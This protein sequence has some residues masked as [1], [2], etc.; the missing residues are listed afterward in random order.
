MY[1][2]P[3]ADSPETVQDL[4]K[5]LQQAIAVELTV[6]PPLFTAL[7]S[8]KDQNSESAK[9][10]HT[11]V[12]E[13]MLHMAVAGNL[14]NAIGGTVDLVSVAKHFE[15]L[16]EPLPY[17]PF[18]EEIDLPMV[19]LQRCSVELVQGLFSRVER[20]PSAWGNQRAYPAQ[21]AKFQ[22]LGG[23]YEA[24]WQTF[25]RLGESVVVPDSIQYELPRHQTGGGRLWQVRSLQ[26]ALDLITENHLKG[27]T[28]ELGSSSEES[29]ADESLK[30]LSHY[31][32]FQEI[33]HRRVPLGE[34]YPVKP[35]CKPT[36]L[37][38]GLV[39]DLNRLF[40]YGF[41]MLVD[42][43]QD[44]FSSNQNI[45]MFC[46]AA[47]TTMNQVMKNLAALMMQVPINEAGETAGPSFFYYDLRELDPEGYV[48]ATRLARKLLFSQ[49]FDYQG[50]DWHR[51]E[52]VF[53]GFQTLVPIPLEA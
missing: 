42:S 2:L 22:T 9:L 34:T 51:M 23:L 31:D 28:S 11:V 27:G 47:M 29:G 36:E 39:T 1:T 41:S 50:A 46:H 35:D 40:D 37:P 49:S 44:L 45:G 48:V 8:I 32:R 14:M 25:H 12:I 33:V 43:L 38:E 52:E 53:K 15:R 19:S 7:C 3:L 20:V 10:I 21:P 24:I 16:P 17:A 6:I 18:L 4:R 13:E 5:M 26:Q 30:K